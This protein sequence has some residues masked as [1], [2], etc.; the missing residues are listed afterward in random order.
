MK[1]KNNPLRI[2]QLV[3]TLNTAVWLGGAVF[4]T[5]VAGPMFFD[6]ALEVVLPKP[7]D[8][9]AARFLI[10]R[11]TAFQ[12]SCACI[13]LITMAL[14]WRLEGGKFPRAQ[15][16]LLGGILLLIVLGMLVL[17]PKL[18]ALHELKYAFY[19]DVQATKEQSEAAGKAFGP[20]HGLSMVGNLV[21]LLGLVAQFILAWKAATLGKGKVNSRS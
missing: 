1:P 11:F 4:F 10:G 21:V 14:G 6:P 16:L 3:G 18:N 2:V 8:G 13:A 7:E 9:V 5:F 19:F 12:L 20:L 15:G 17:A